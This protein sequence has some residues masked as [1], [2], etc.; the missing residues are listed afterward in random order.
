MTEQEIRDRQ[1]FVAKVAKELD[2]YDSL[3]E[4]RQRYLDEYTI[5]AQA[6]AN[7]AARRAAER[8]GRDPTQVGEWQ[9]YD[10]PET[11]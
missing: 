10:V 6:D 11:D 3:D 2:Q 4:A 1:D 9:L 7:I 5:L 8:D